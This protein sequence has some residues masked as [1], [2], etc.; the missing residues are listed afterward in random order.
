MSV[1][2]ETSIGDIVIDLFTDKAPLASENFIKLCKIKFYHNALLLDIQKDYLCQ[3]T[4]TLHAKTTIFEKCS[5][6]KSD[7][8]FKVEQNGLKFNK[9]GLVATG[10]TGPNMCDSDFFITLTNGPLKPL[11]QKHTIF[12]IV[13]EGI[14]N[15]QKLNTVPC[16]AKNRPL[17]DL[18]IFHTHILDDPFNDPEGLI[19]PDKSPEPILESA[20]RL[21]VNENLEVKELQ[22]K[23]QEDI[24]EEIKQQNSRLKVLNLQ[25]MEDIPDMEIKPPENVLF[26]CKLNRSTQEKDLGVIFSR[27]GP[28]KSCNIIRDWKTGDSLQY[29]FIEFENV[30]ACEQAYLKMNNAQID[31]RRIKVDFSQSVSKLWNRFNFQKN[32]KSRS[33][34]L[35]REKEFAK[36][37]SQNEA[38]KEEKEF[39]NHRERSPRS[40]RHNADPPMQKNEHWGTRRPEPPSIPPRLSKPP[41][42]PVENKRQR[43][44]RSRSRSG[45]K[46]KG[47]KM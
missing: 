11:D 14:E 5:G 12:G 24:E 25:T 31:D 37:K 32:D 29:A 40:K 41:A 34:W 18:R 15:I 46:A 36:G 38:K 1:L 13:A 47:T 33:N 9:I 23:T 28:V 43:K 21:T 30:E 20:D 2:L 42:P 19:E 6:L 10:N 8:Y 35:E 7:R 16:D 26:V 22:G 4:Q 27:F 45:E 17:Y 44:S 3:I 39:K